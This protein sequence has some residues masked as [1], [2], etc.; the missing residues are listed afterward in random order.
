MATPLAAWGFGAGS[1]TTVTDDSGN[2]CTMTLAGSA[3]YT[4]SGHTGPGLTNTAANAP[5]G[6][7]T[8]PAVTG[9][10]VTLLCWV[11]PL[12]LTAGG[13]NFACGV[14]QSNSNTDIAI[15]TQR[16]AVGTPN[17]LQA[18]IRI[19]GGLLTANGAAMTVGTWAHVA[20]TFDGTN[21]KLYTNGVLTTTVANTGTLSLATTM[22][23][24]GTLAGV[25]AGTQV[26]ID[27]VQYFNSALTITDIVTAMNTPVGVT[28]DTSG[29]F[30][31]F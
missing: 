24:A 19:S 2:G 15:F 8:V 4:A 29:F 16:S 11:K 7:A 1:G 3:A 27:D 28:A 9:T 12:Q 13:T 5:G 17:V 26:V 6:T 14:F 22:Y 23:A 21:I 25:A 30:E 18:D 20:V 10:G 31:F